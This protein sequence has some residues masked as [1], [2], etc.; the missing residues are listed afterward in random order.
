MSRQR[1]YA[2]RHRAAD[3]CHSCSSPTYA[4]GVHCQKHREAAQLRARKRA[5]SKPWERGKRGRP[6]LDAE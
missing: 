6:P 2:D 3:L 1:A 5:G 4:G